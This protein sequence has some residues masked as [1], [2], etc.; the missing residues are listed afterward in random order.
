MLWDYSRG[1]EGGVGGQTRKLRPSLIFQNIF[2]LSLPL[3]IPVTS[4]GDL[5]RR[6]SYPNF[7]LVPIV[8]TYVVLV[9]Y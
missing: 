5:N 6:R 9:L 2:F 7:A 8:H 3:P 4:P 1:E